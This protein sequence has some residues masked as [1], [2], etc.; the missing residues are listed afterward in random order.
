VGNNRANGFNYGVNG[1]PTT[2]LIDRRGMVR[3]ISVGVSEEEL[4]LCGSA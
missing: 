1:I 3:F 2:V 4:G